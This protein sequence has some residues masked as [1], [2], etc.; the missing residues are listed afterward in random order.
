M[1]N[2]LNPEQ[3][4][5]NIKKL[6]AISKAVQTQIKCKYIAKYAKEYLG[7]TDKQISELFVGK[8]S[9]AHRLNMLNTAIRTMD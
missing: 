8:Y 4:S 9:M 2:Q 7:K 1:Y 6:E 5:I 3:E